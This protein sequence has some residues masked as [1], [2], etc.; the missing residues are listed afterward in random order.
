MR[1]QYTHQDFRLL[2][3]RNL[4]EEA[5]KSQNCPNP[6]LIG[7]PSVAAPNIVQLKSRHNQHRSAKSA[8]V[9]VHLAA[10]ERPQSTSALSVT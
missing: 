9:F 8:V 1:A 2:L 4:I 10:R 7:R 3:V 5:G 6:S